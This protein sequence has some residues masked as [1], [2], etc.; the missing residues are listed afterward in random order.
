[1]PGYIIHQMN[2]FSSLG[3]G[4]AGESTYWL[5]LVLAKSVVRAIPCTN[6]CEAPRRS[7]RDRLLEGIDWSVWFQ[8]RVTTAKGSELH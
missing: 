8:T 2:K 4:Q 7:S 3:Q 5:V 1:M 6:G